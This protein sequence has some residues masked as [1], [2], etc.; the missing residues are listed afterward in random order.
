LGR[1]K[2]VTLDD[3]AAEIGVSRFLVCRALTGK[4]GINEDTRQIIEKAAAR[5]GYKGKKAKKGTEIITIALLV[6]EIEAPRFFWTTIIRGIEAS[7]RNHGYDL[8]LRAVTAEEIAN[9]EIPSMISEGRVKG[10]LI[11]G[12][13]CPDYIALFEKI[14]CQVVLVDNFVVTTCHDAILIDDWDGSYLVTKHLI[15]LGHK[16]IG[17]AGKISD[18]WSWVQRFHGFLAALHEYGLSYDRRNSIAQNG[19]ED[20][21]SFESMQHE[22]EHIKEMPSA[23]VC[24]NDKTAHFLIEALN[25]K[26]IKIPDDVSITGFDD[27]PDEYPKIQAA[28]TTVRVYGEDIGKS[29]FEHLLWRM[30]NPSARPRRIM[31]GVQFIN[32]T[33]TAAPIANKNRS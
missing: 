11:T 7:A 2:K 29:A 1:T 16:K 28:L 9:S 6:D 25:I 21:W 32:G 26:G 33:T 17:Y 31:I 30:S 22:V 10:V 15:E 23:W 13:F 20:M 8:L 3:V 27:L 12:N 19:E 5:L 14:D 24:N 4:P 18:H